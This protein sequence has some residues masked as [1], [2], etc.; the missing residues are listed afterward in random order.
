MEG[1][2][3][4]DSIV[5]TI[6]PEAVVFDAAGNLYVDQTELPDSNIVVFGGADSIVKVIGNSIGSGTEWKY[7]RGMAFDASGNLYVVSQGD[8]NS[9]NTGKLIKISDPLGSATKT[10]L[11]SGLQKPKGISINGNNV[12]ITEN[13]GNKV[14]RYD[15]ATF[16][17]L[18]SVVA[19]SPVDVYST[20]CK[21]Y[22]TE[23]GLNLVRK[24]DALNL[25]SGAISTVLDTLRD[26]MGIV[27]DGNANLFVAEHKKN[28]VTFFRE[29]PMVSYQPWI[30]Q[31]S[32]FPA[33]GVLPHDSTYSGWQV[34]DTSIATIDTNHL[35]YGWR[36]GLFN[37]TYLHGADTL[38]KEYLV[39]TCPY[40][41]CYHADIYFDASIPPGAVDTANYWYSTDTTIASPIGVGGFWGNSPGNV[42]IYH[43]VDTFNI[44]FYLSVIPTWGPHITSIVSDEPAGALCVN[45]ALFLQADSATEF[46][47]W[48]TSNGNA[49]VEPWG[50]V[51]PIDTGA[52]TIYVNGGNGC[53]N[54]GDS[55]TLLFIGD[56]DPGTVS[57]ATSVCKGDTIQV[58]DPVPSGLWSVEDTTA[59]VDATGIVT[60]A[61]GGSAKVIYTVSNVCGDFAA[62]LKI[63]VDTPTAGTITGPDTVCQGASIAA[64]DSVSGGT[65]FTDATAFSI[66]GSEITGVSAGTGNIYYTTNG[67]CG[68][69]TVTRLIHVLGLPASVSITGDDS[70]CN[71]QAIVLSGS[72]TGDTSHYWVT[73][74]ASVLSVDTLGNVTGNAANNSAQILYIAV[75]H[76]GADS[77]TK[78]IG[79]K[80]TANAGSISGPGSV[81]VGATIALAN[82]TGSS[83]GTWISTNEAAATVD[84]TGVV[85]GVSAEAGAVS[86]VY[87][88]ETATCG[89][90]TTTY[91]IS[92]NAVPSVSSLTGAD[93]VCAGSTIGLIPGDTSGNVSLIW[94]SSDGTLASVDASGTVTGVGGGSATITVDAHNDCGDATATHNVYVIAQ[95]NAGTVSGPSNICVSGVGSFTTD[96]DAG[97]V[98]TLSDPLDAFI[99][100]DGTV[101]PNWPVT[102]TAIYTA[103]N[104]CGTQTA[105][106]DFSID[107]DDPGTISGPAEICVTDGPTYSSDQTDP[108]AWWDLSDWS[109]A[110][111]GMNPDYTASLYPISGGTETITYSFN[112]SCGFVYSTYT[113]LID[114]LPV[115][116]S[117]SGSGTVCAG[118]TL[119]LTDMTGAPGGTWT[120]SNNAAA[121]ITSA[122][123]VM[124]GIS[125]SAGTTTISYTVDGGVCGTATATFGVSVNPLPDAGTVTGA[126]S[127]CMPSVAT[128]TNT[129]ANGPVSWSSSDASVAT[130]SAGGVV[131]GA[132]SG[133]ALII[134][135]V[136]NTCGVAEAEQAIDISMPPNAGTISGPVNIC[137]S[138]TGSLTTDGDAGGVWTLS[139]TWDAYIGTDGTVWPSWPATETAIYTV[140]NSCGTQTATFDFSIDNDNP[141]TIGGP[142]EICETAVPEYSSD[143][144]D[145]SASW[146][147][148]SWSLASIGT[149]SA[150]TANLYPISGGTEIIT[151]S[152]SNSCGFV[153]TTYNVL[154]DAAPVAGSIAGSASVCVGQSATLTDATGLPGGLWAANN[155]NATMLGNVVT[156]AS[157]GTDIISYTVSNLCGTAT[158]TLPIVV[159]DV[160]VVGPVS[161]P[162]TVCPATTVTLTD[163]TA[164]GAW[165]VTNSHA[166]ISGGGVLTGATAGIDTVHYQKTNSCGVTT[167]SYVDTIL[168]NA[169]V[170]GITGPSVLCTGD[171]AVF[172]GAGLVY[173][174]T[175]WHLSNGAATVVPV[176]AASVKIAGMTAGTDTLSLTAT[177]TCSS[178]T[179]TMAIAMQAPLVLTPISGRDTLCP[180][181][182]DTLHAGVSAGAASWVLTGSAASVTTAND[183]MAIIAGLSSGAFSAVYSASNACGIFADT[184]Q[185]YV[186]PGAPAAGAITGGPAVCVGQSIT[187]A[188]A[189]GATGGAWAA[190]NSFA[191]DTANIVRG[192]T[193]G[194][195]TISYT[196]SNMCGSNTATHTVTVLPLADPGFITGAGTICTTSPATLTDG[197]AGGIWVVTNGNASVSGGVVTGLAEGMDTV[198][199][200]VVNSCNADTALHPITINTLPGAGVIAGADTACA[201]HT[202]ELTD[203]VSGGLWVSSNGHATITD[204]GLVTGV[205]AGTDTIVYAVSN[206]C[207]VNA[208]TLQL[209]VMNAPVAGTISG[210]DTVCAGDS[211]VLTLTGATAGG[212]WQSSNAATAT[213]NAAGHVMGMTPGSVTISYTAANICDTV[214]ATHSLLVLADSVCNLRVVNAGVVT[215]TLAVYPNPNTGTFNVLLSGPVD[216]PMQVTVTDVP[217]RKVKELSGVT[218][219]T[220]AISLNEAAGI[221]LVTVRTEHASF[222]T[223]VV[224]N[225]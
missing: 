190:S 97:G 157:V 142:A 122:T 78:T 102:E 69:D 25:D 35:L 201:G 155:A 27:V 221:Y 40:R 128:F 75:N 115:A 118:Q 143:Q 197:V 57:G 200:V 113:V 28:R 110:S 130:V 212:Y 171:T 154:I 23:R 81:C 123:G 132:A 98:W 7:P 20:G 176:S 14:C 199:Y 62:Y 150:T 31:F 206:A 185:M 19:D 164:G 204:S 146:G 64:M 33:P 10:L 93:S 44:P 50:T 187:L 149:T 121:T 140:T 179:A 215:E 172:S 89:T 32:Y 88:V 220:L 222:V 177:T 53:Y 203:A 106:F 15:L 133:S 2:V 225:G 219:K 161:G 48:S 108:S 182:T 193:A 189:G 51:W 163:T 74:D 6:S 65:W 202:I 116:G 3:A 183:T 59:T 127:L 67:T 144:T 37:L 207:G 42:M 84:A 5:S 174:T 56:L 151:Y 30:C 47:T 34:S 145:P 80:D 45:N 135:S 86:I 194:T 107:N 188:D 112:N 168:S 208:A 138:G 136:T 61:H 55:I 91:S 52:V 22:W 72:A 120:S 103:T 195:D 49:Y 95:P 160:P 191:T 58:S 18:D 101:W 83:W 223:K 71:G 173:T 104:S 46:E 129:G 198:M 167:R 109:M 1:H 70:V 114:A 192:V 213:V 196:V 77:A 175:A 21:V 100:A 159:N 218:N 76:C 94:S 68:A 131:S 105:T 162:V 73:S 26:P 79:V 158:A 134:A 12:Y 209:T 4:N 124:T 210:Q 181:T 111:I 60:G 16:H 141:G 126:E 184:L 148:S 11:L 63:T 38:H 205:S 153:Y 8:T 170:A 92:V 147:L 36:D 166:S 117:I 156:G 180:G 39:T 125:S 216:E 43:H 54:T 211:V 87:K 24:T 85:T 13:A 99:A 152:F 9:Y 214:T 96:G 137:V 178:A 41:V 224:I 165:S 217:G 169:A 90:N 82:T 119:T 29:I 17:K 66:S 139:D 186:H